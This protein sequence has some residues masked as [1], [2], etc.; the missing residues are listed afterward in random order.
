MYTQC[1]APINQLYLHN[2]LSTPLYLIEL[3]NKTQKL[4]NTLAL[5]P[6]NK[7]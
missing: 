4:N 7:I 3:N 6:T 2:L 5:N 1:C